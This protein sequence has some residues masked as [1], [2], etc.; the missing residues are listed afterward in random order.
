MR[1]VRIAEL[2][3]VR[4]DPSIL[5]RASQPFPTLLRTLDAL[6]LATALALRPSRP[7]LALATHDAE[8]AAGAR[9]VGF[10]VLGT[11]AVGRG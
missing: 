10:R 4:L 1:R 5:E 2:D 7:D 6:H 8:L 9:A 11:V 3:L